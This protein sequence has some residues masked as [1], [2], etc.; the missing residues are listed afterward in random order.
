MRRIVGILAISLLV[1][2]A[3]R[4]AIPD[5]I[6]REGNSQ[7]PPVAIRIVGEVAKALDLSA[8]DLSRLPHKTIKVKDPDGSDATYEGVPLVEAADGYRAVFA[9]PELDPAFTDRLILLTDCRNG[10]KLGVKD[11]PFRVIVPDEKRHSRWARQVIMLKV[12]RG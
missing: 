11:G 10:E 2:V 12:G 3:S 7:S 1:A 4:S 5:L 9:L 8:E 6:E